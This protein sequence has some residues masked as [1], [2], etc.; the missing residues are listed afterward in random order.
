[1]NLV[2]I[3]EILVTLY[4]TIQTRKMVNWRQHRRLSSREN[5]VV[6]HKSPPMS[7]FANRKITTNLLLLLELG[8]SLLSSLLLALALLKESLRN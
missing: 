3:R 7:P 5:G 6:H 4:M 2:E 1:M 8:G